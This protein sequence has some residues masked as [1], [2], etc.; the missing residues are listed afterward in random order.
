MRDQS[1]EIA[2]VVVDEAEV[3]EETAAAVVV[4]ADVV[5]VPALF[6][7]PQTVREAVRARAASRAACWP[8]GRPCISR[9]MVSLRTSLRRLKARLPGERRAPLGPRS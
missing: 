9:P 7:Q 1:V 5:V 3:L 8:R 4:E 2:R 6:P